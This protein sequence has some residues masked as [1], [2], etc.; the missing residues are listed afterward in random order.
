V[1]PAK[2]NSDHVATR[3]F[4]C[5]LNSSRNFAC[6]TTT[7]ANTAIAV[8]NNSQCGERENPTT[9]DNL[10]NAIDGNQLFYKAF[11]FVRL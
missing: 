2:V 1:C 4:E 6:F 5:F 10:G 7:K 3:S 9:F 8:T 11:C